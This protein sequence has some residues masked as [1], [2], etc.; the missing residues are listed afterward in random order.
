MSAQLQPVTFSHRQSLHRSGERITD[1]YFP[2][3][4]VASITTLLADGAF[5]EATTVGAEGMLGAEAFLSPEPISAGETFIQVPGANVALRLG[6]GAFRQELDRRGALYDLIGRYIEVLLAQ[7]MQVAGCNA[8][9]QV[10]A[11]CCRWLLMTHD[12]IASNSFEL[13][14]ELLGVMLGVR[15]QTVTVVAGALQHAGLI[16]YRHGRIRVLDR[17][18]L[19]ARSCECYELMRQRYDRLLGRPSPG[20]SGTS[21]SGPSRLPAGH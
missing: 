11:R 10:Q 19:E 5:I 16:A 1:I 12:R 9:H 18:G 2:N 4:G 17:A 3:S 7:V 8:S 20:S 21:S 15:R 14:H 6:V 13:S